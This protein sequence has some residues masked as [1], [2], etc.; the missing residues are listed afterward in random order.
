LN[1]THFN[2]TQFHSKKV[3]KKTRLQQKI[4]LN[5]SPF[6]S[7]KKKNSSISSTP[8]APME[9][10]DRFKTIA[11]ALATASYQFQIQVGVFASGVL[12]EVFPLKKGTR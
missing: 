8:K 11:Q 2:P 7:L 12:N 1:S 5:N 6:L 3:A 9:L 10:W 4:L